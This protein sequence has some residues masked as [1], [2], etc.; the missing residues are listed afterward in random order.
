MAVVPRSKRLKVFVKLLVTCS[1]VA[2]IISFVP[3]DGVLESLYMASWWWI[4]LSF[5]FNLL[6]HYLNSLQMQMI[7]L[8]LE[9]TL[10]TWQIYKVNL[11][12]KFYGLFLPGYLAGGAI[13]WY[14]FQKQ[15]SKPT[16]ALAA[17]VLNRLLETSMTI[18][19]GVCFW[20]ADQSN[21][22]DSVPLAPLLAFTLFS[23][24]LYL[25]SFNSRTHVWIKHTFKCRIVPIWLAGRANSF[26]DALAT[27]ETLPAQRHFKILTMGVVRHFLAILAMYAVIVGLHLDISFATLGWVR[28]VVTLAMMLPIAIGGIGVRELTFIALLAPYGIAAE[29]A[30]TLSL[31]VFAKGLVFALA[32]G[33]LECQRLLFSGKEKVHKNMSN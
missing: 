16:E 10:T 25:V 32:G 26:L 17:L 6:V 4:I 12:T 3:L 9:M 8:H 20:L 1:L 28:S 21:T 33:L 5:G 14:H 18:G 7:T 27:Y 2:W 31:V 13:R 24:V 29:E 19:L 11:I 30:L 23:I 15:D 22:S